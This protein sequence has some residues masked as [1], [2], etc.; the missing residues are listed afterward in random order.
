MSVVAIFDIAVH[1]QDMENFAEG[2]LVADGVVVGH[3]RQPMTGP[4]GRYSTNPVVKYQTAKGNV[5][6]FEDKTALDQGLV[7]G[8]KV[9]VRYM[10][11]RPTFAVVDDQTQETNNLAIDIVFVVWALVFL[12][13]TIISLRGIRRA[14][15]VRQAMDDA[16]RMTTS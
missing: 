1:Q 10:P 7:S 8:Q 2:S 9:R 16:D 11:D 3:T 4:G 5:V 15:R 6:T 14:I 13:L 12:A